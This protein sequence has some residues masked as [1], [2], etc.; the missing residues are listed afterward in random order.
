MYCEKRITTVF[1]IE[2]GN[3]GL[4]GSAREVPFDASTWKAVPEGVNPCLSY[5]TSPSEDEEKELL[6]CAKGSYQKALVAGRQ[7]WSG[8]DLRGSARKFSA[9]YARSR[10]AL[11]RRIDERF[12]V[13]YR[14]LP[15][16]R[17]AHVVCR[18]SDGTC[19]IL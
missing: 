8:A 1:D 18:R 6:K 16:D 11:L 13:T 9:K 2:N 14:I 7:R 19:F 12:D 5:S 15:F 3:F 4:V 17:R 10:V